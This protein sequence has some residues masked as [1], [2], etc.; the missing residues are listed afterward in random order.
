M[1]SYSGD[2]SQELSARN[3]LM[4]IDMSRPALAADLAPT[5]CPDARLVR[6]RSEQAPYAL[7]A[8]FPQRQYRAGCANC[9]VCFAEAVAERVMKW[10]QRLKAV[11]SYETMV[12]ESNVQFCTLSFPPHEDGTGPKKMPSEELCQSC[13]ENFTVALHRYYERR[14][15]VKLKEAVNLF[16]FL[17]EGGRHGRRHFHMLYCA[18]PGYVHPHS[19]DTG[20]SYTHYHRDKDGQVVLDPRTDR[21]RRTRI[22][23]D[24]LCEIWETVIRNH[25]GFD[26]L[27]HWF[28]DNRG[29]PGQLARYVVSKYLTKGYKKE[30]EL[31]ITQEKKR[32]YR[33]RAMQQ[34]PPWDELLDWYRDRRFNLQGKPHR[35]WIGFRLHFREF[36]EENLTAEMKALASSF[37][38]HYEKAVHFQDY[39]RDLK[40]DVLVKATCEHLPHRDELAIEMMRAVGEE[41]SKHTEAR[42]VFGQEPGLP[43]GLELKPVMVALSDRPVM[44]PARASFI[45]VATYYPADG[46]FS[47]VQSSDNPASLVT[48]ENRFNLCGASHWFPLD[49]VGTGLVG[50]IEDTEAFQELVSWDKSL[51]ARLDRVIEPVLTRCLP[52]NAMSYMMQGMPGAS[53]RVFDRKRAKDIAYGFDSVFDISPMGYPRV[54]PPPQ[55]EFIVN[56][57]DAPLPSPQPHIQEGLHRAFGWDEPAQSLPINYGR[58]HLKRGQSEIIRRIRQ[59]ESGIYNLPTGYG[60]SLCYQIPWV[61]D[62]ITLVVSP[63]RALIRN[64]IA[65]CNELGIKATWVA[66]SLPDS[67]RDDVLAQVGIFPG[68]PQREPAVLYT[69]PEALSLRKRKDGSFRYLPG[70]LIN[71][72][73]RVSHLVVDEAHCVT[74]W[75]DYR[76]SYGALPKYVAAWDHYPDVVSCFSATIS[77]RILEDLRLAF[78]DLD[79]FAL[80]M[81]RPNLIL[82]TVHQPFEEWFPRHVSQLK[83]PAVLYAGAIR[84]A[85]HRAQELRDQYGVAAAHYHAKMPSGQRAWTERAFLNGDIDVLCATVA[86]GMGV[87]PPYIRTVIHDNFPDTIEDYAQ[88]IGRGGRDGEDTHCYILRPGRHQSE[89]ENLF[90][91]RHCLWQ[92][93]A[94][95]HGQQAA[96]CGRCSHCQGDSQ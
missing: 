90:Y 81:E 60:K 89:V 14:L 64:Q 31:G 30:S 51:S 79:F 88:Q 44:H 43:V 62:G 84:N 35:R 58:F 80:P 48:P 39:D 24:G 76:P 27:Q 32:P 63:L 87:D 52:G 36:T 7:L 25:G 95:F 70:H 77:G 3:R 17:E 68:R 34:S 42:A 83:L 45:S 4:Q 72:T 2:V 38:D 50:F 9:P 85:E 11:L 18:R 92:Y 59:H 75:S 20:R 8:G 12:R 29:T 74:R 16:G 40:Q 65:M 67:Q 15:G 61:E 37:L 55:G 6:I 53:A 94:Y 19:I 86:Y 41:M 96:P 10:S 13:W 91:S 33:V 57:S 21:P 56:L 78:G 93:V 5:R 28:R 54:D 66:G 82:H 71:G 46:T 1:I 73:L 26:R 47:A 22:R 49:D 23:V 69:A